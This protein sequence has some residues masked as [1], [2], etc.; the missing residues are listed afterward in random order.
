LLP[1]LCLAGENVSLEVLQLLNPFEVLTR[2]E[3]SA[4]ISLEKPAWI[5]YRVV[6]LRSQRGH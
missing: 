3:E 4:S 2:P 5:V 6:F 1:E